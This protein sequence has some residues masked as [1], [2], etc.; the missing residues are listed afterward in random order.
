M[1]G[2]VIPIQAYRS[3]VGPQEYGVLRISRQ[4]AH[5]GG[6]DASPTY[7]SPL[8]P[9]DI[10]VTRFFHRP[11]RQ[12]GHSAVGMIKLMKNP[13]DLTGNQTRDLPA[14]SAAPQQTALPHAHDVPYFYSRIVK[15]YSS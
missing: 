4:S 15:R 1:E 14:C 2:N 13:N 3:P 12:R 11:S 6:K 5:E 8:P 7:R 10:H 9:G